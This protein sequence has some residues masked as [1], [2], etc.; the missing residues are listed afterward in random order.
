MT[1]YTFADDPRRPVYER[2]GSENTDPQEPLC[3]TSANYASIRVAFAETAAVRVSASGYR[4]L[5]KG[6]DGRFYCR[7]TLTLRADSIGTLD[8]LFYVLEQGRADGYITPA[9][10]ASLRDQL[11]G[12][13]PMAGIA[14]SQLNPTPTHPFPAYTPEGLEALRPHLRGY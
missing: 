4:V 6:G 10:E 3:R 2:A 14:W 9:D 11:A 13:P 12:W 1:L 8:Q 5:T 7:S